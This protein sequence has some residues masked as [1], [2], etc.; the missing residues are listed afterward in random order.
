MKWIEEYY[1]W[2]GDPK[3]TR[4]YNNYTRRNIE[5][6]LGDGELRSRLDKKLEM[7]GVRVG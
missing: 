5:L 4:A 2:K 6:F 7:L 3:F 1:D